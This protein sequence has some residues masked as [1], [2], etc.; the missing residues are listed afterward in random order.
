MICPFLLGPPHAQYV[1]SFWAMLDKFEFLSSIPSMMVVALP[2]FLV[3][4]RMRIRC[5]SFS[6][7][8]QT[9]RSFGSP[10]VE[11]TSAMTLTREL[12]TEIYKSFKGLKLI[13]SC[14]RSWAA[15]MNWNL[16]LFC[17]FLYFFRIYYGKFTL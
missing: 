16:G 12:S 14:F 2:N 17:C 10:H 15:L 4:R 1:L 8:P 5:C 13:F 11:Q 3:S 9:H 6:I 7:S